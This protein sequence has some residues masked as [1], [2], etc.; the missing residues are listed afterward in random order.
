M[1]SKVAEALKRERER[2]ELLDRIDS[3]ERKIDEM[4]K[5]FKGAEKPAPAK[6]TRSTKQEAKTS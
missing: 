6:R 1:A 3:L 2:R 4:Y 5:A